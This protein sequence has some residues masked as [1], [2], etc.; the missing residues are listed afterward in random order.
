MVP[1][2]HPTLGEVGPVGG[3]GAILEPRDEGTRRDAALAGYTA[4]ETVL[5]QMTRLH[6]EHSGSAV[7]PPTEPKCKGARAGPPGGALCYA[8]SMGENDRQGRTTSVGEMKERRAGSSRR[9]S[10]VGGA[11]AALSGALGND[12]LLARIAAGNAN[13]D[14]LLEFLVQ[15]LAEMRTAQLAEIELANATANSIRTTMGESERQHEKPNPKRWH[16]AAQLYQRA[17]QALC[18]G[19]LHRG[20]ALVEQAAKEDRRAFEQLSSLVET[21]AEAPSMEDAPL[22]TPSS[23]IACTECREP[24]GVEVAEEILRVNLDGNPYI[25]GQRREL[26]PWWTDLEEEEEEDAADG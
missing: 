9:R 1:E 3:L 22:G 17:A 18:A 23:A 25:K 16:P 7:F 26:D 14:D 8:P 19:Q 10:A 12:E 2:L 15:R 20:A 11:L 6:D 21:E 24:E 13:R 5:G 4:R